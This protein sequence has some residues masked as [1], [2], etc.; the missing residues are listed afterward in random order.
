[1]KVLVLDIGGSNVKLKATG[2][3]EPRKFVSGPTLTPDALV[4]QV[5][6]LTADSPFD[7]M[8]VG[9]PGRVVHGKIVAD[10]ANLGG[11]WRGFDFAQ[12]F[13]CPVKLINDAAMQAL[14]SYQSG[15]QLFLGLGTGLGSALI[16][17][18]L[19]VP[20]ELAH[21]PYRKG[22]TYEEYLGAAG[23]KRLGT[24]KWRR[25]V[26]KVVELLTAALMPDHVVVGGGNAKKLDALPTG[27]SLGNNAHAFLGGF[28]LWKAS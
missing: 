20:L 28:K 27:V 1:M 25:H 12:A 14:G 6:E 22:L 26:W 18:G 4:K 21:L 8:S 10:P 11:Q 3:R 16:V 24:K 9:Y 5:Q 2:W 15:H 17:N 7:V 23:K 19:V 13:G